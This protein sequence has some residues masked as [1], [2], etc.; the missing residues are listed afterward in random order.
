MEFLKILLEPIDTKEKLFEK[1]L[2]T[3]SYVP[4]WFDNK[5]WNISD[6]NKRAELFPT[7]EKIENRLNELKNQISQRKEAVEK[8]LKELK[9][10]PYMS[11]LIKKIQEFAF[12]RQEGELQIGYHNFHGVPLKRVICKKFGISLEDI[13]FLTDEEI[14]ENLKGRNHNLN[15]LINERSNYCFMIAKDGKCTIATGAGGKRLADEIKRKVVEAGTVT[16]KQEL[17]GVVGSPGFAKGRVR[18]ING[19]DQIDDLQIG[20]IMVV[21]GTSV[22]YLSAMQRAAAI[23]SEIGGIT[24][25]SAV[26]ARELGKP[27]LTRVESAT[28]V[29]KNGDIVEVDADSGIVKIIKK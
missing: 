18:V 27:C 19:L 24:S 3:Y 15:N 7:R 26:I 2:E 29:L 12:L 21:S 14:M 20:E 17:K 25:H 1:H 9:P 13:K 10:G 16:A 5:P 22:E 6:I 4:M 23:I 8:I 28:K 11:E